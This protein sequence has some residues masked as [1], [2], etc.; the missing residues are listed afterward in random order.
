MKTVDWRA[1]DYWH[2]KHGDT[3]RWD[4]S[5]DD[6]ENAFKAGYASR[7]EEINTLRKQVLDLQER[8]AGATKYISELEKCLEVAEKAL[9]FHCLNHTDIATL[10]CCEALAQIKAIKE[11]TTNEVLSSTKISSCEGEK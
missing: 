3:R 4:Y 9:L 7:D 6:I 2:E 10:P 1:E 8:Y 11:G 5:R